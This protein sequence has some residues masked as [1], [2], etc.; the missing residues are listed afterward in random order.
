MLSEAWSEYADANASH[1]ENRNL[2]WEAGKAFILGKIM[3]YVAS[4]KKNTQK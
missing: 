3:S 4:Y 1:R 2:F